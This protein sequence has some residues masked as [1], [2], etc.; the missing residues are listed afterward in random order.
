MPTASKRYVT[1]RPIDYDEDGNDGGTWEES[2]RKQRRVSSEEDEGDG[3][4]EQEEENYENNHMEEE[5]DEEEEDMDMEDV[6]ERVDSRSARRRSINPQGQPP[7]AGVIKKVYVEN[8]MCHRKLTMNL[9]RNVNFIHGQN[10][11]GKSAILAAIQICLGAGAK[12][13]H[14]ARNLKELVRKESGDCIARVQVTLLNGGDDAYEH[15]TYGDT[16][17]IE[18]VIPLSGSGV[19]KLLDHEGKERSRKRRDLDSMLDHLNIQVENPV[20]ILDQE[21]A[22]KFL[23]GKASDK[24]NFFMKATELERL[25]NTYAS[26][27]DK[28]LEMQDTKDKVA[29]GLEP[30]YEYILKLQKELKDHDK[31][32]K[33]EA[34]ISEFAIEGAWSEYSAETEKLAQQETVLTAFEQKVEK[35]KDDLEKARN[36]S[37]ENSDEK[38]ELNKKLQELTAETKE[39]SDRKI[40]LEGEFRQAKLPIRQAENSLRSVQEE[41]KSAKRRHK[42]AVVALQKIRNEILEKANSAQSEE[43][44][45]VALLTKA[46]EDLS[47]AKKESIECKKAVGEFLKK[48]EELASPCGDAKTQMDDAER[49]RNGIRG[50][51]ENLRSSSEGSS[52]AMFGPKCALMMRKVE[53]AKRNGRFRGEVVGPIG[54]CLKIMAGKEKLASLAELALGGGVLGRFI[55]TCDSDRNHF[56][57]LRKEIGCGYRD[58]NV[59]QQSPSGRYNVHLPPSESV[60]TPLTVLSI[61]NDLVFNC[62]VDN[63]RADQTAVMESKQAVEQIL[64]ENRG[65]ASRIRGG[66]IKKCHF[67]PDGDYY[68]VDRKG[69]ANMY[70]NEARMKQSIG[71]DK[72]DAIKEAISDEKL[73]SEDLATFKENLDALNKER[74]QY[75]IQWNNAHKSYKSLLKAIDKHQNTIDDIKADAES[76]DNVTHDTTAL[77]EDVKETEKE[78]EEMGERADEIKRTI[79][80]LKQPLNAI[81]ANLKESNARNSKIDGECQDV[82]NQLEKIIQLEH[83]REDIIAK[84]TQKLEKMQQEVAKVLAA[85]D[86][87]RKSQEQKMLKA[88]EM[89]Y[90]IRKRLKRKEKER[91]AMNDEDAA[92]DI[93]EVTVEDHEITPQQEIQP[94]SVR[95]DS[96]WYEDQIN[97]GENKV[98]RLKERL[99]IQGRNPTV[100]RHQ[101]KRAENDLKSKKEM[102]DRIEDNFESLSTDV[103]DRKKK[104]KAF[105]GTI[106]NTTN[107]TFDNLLNKKGSSGQIDFQHKNRELLL[108]VQ[109]DNQNQHTQTKDVKALSGGERSYVT[110]SLLLALGESLETPFRVMDEFDVFLDPLARKLALETMIAVAKEMSHRQFIFITPQDLSNI[111][112]DDRLKIFRMKAPTRNAL[113]GG[114]TQQTID[115]PR[116]QDD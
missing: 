110:L 26:T 63:V 54:S 92:E 32:E 9:S 30:A 33:L 40:K 68:S 23:M 51:L 67:L 107:M 19:Y 98:N 108:C 80:D 60:D 88:Q 49:Q 93:G 46:E 4:M 95:H 27:A 48:Y 36:S 59:F 109:K 55:V 2:P 104:W 44:R 3:H 35:R 22:K 25:D 77:E 1:K 74:M 84:K 24:Y 43:A 99:N 20:A 115:F 61:S 17:T 90:M 15:D 34:K 106:S 81:E 39:A 64:L 113:V 78:C 62:L 31:V 41:M 28:L 29:K 96:K 76:A 114:P 94:R 79:E 18:R 21:E 5:E 101:L 65:D 10:G 97:S 8:F 37:S 13:T 87:C 45:R 91:A 16:I 7:E 112:T 14:R 50:K 82:R 52:V 89:E 38:D 72:S 56:M 6:E 12:R 102:V 103:K 83:A 71:V 47:T 86:E 100:V 75:K 69:Q 111:K 73:V 85:C 11:S 58:C 105:R 66:Q 53:E 70:A 42:S 116:S 57:Q